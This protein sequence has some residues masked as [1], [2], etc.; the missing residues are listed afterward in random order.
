MKFLCCL[1]Y[2]MS[3]LTGID[4]AVCVVELQSSL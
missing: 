1:A 2:F 4:Y 3:Y